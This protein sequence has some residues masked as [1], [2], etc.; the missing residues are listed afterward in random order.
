MIDFAMEEPLDDAMEARRKFDESKAEATQADEMAEEMLRANAKVDAILSQEEAQTIR[1]ESL[2][3]K[4][5]RL[6]PHQ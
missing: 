2:A 4:S 3:E 1:I 6:R 5:L